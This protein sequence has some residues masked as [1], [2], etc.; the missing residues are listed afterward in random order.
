MHIQS[1]HILSQLTTDRK[2]TI[3]QNAV[4]TQW[5]LFVCK[6]IVPFND[7]IVYAFQHWLIY[8]CYQ[9]MS[10]IWVFF[11]LEAIW[12]GSSLTHTISISIINQW[13][14]MILHTK[15]CIETAHD[16]LIVLICSFAL[17]LNSCTIFN[18]MKTYWLTLSSKLCTQWHHLWIS[19]ENKSAVH[20]TETC[21]HYIN[22]I[23]AFDHEWKLCYIFM[24]II[25]WIGRT[26]TVKSKWTEN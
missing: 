5:K 8:D 19:T 25:L 6:T 12:N 22:G 4:G 10:L 13:N 23:M 21:V 2:K 7:W 9:I 24:L 14:I 18:T 20:I 16:L 15:L 11:L 1:F 17:S 26:Q 3:N